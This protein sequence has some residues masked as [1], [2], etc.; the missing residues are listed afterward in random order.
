MRLLLGTRTYCLIGYSSL[1]DKNGVNN[2]WLTISLNIWRMGCLIGCLTILNVEAGV[3]IDVLEARG[4]GSGTLV[5]P[6]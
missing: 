5:L 2:C 3:R 4:P 1:R 6:R